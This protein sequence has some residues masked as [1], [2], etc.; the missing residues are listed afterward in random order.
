MVPVGSS[1]LFWAVELLS[2]PLEQPDSMDTAI[3]AARVRL[4]SFFILF[5]QISVARLTLP[6]LGEWV[7]DPAKNEIRP[8][9][10]SFS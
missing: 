6:E 10:R 7:P 8:A 4:R 3:S 2:L 9:G 5:L 1:P